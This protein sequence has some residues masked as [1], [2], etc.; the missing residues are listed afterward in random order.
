MNESRRTEF[1]LQRNGIIDPEK[2]R[3]RSYKW[4]QLSGVAITLTLMEPVINGRQQAFSVI[5]QFRRYTE[6]LAIKF[7]I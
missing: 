2:I 4:A 7:A 6:H 3:S 5:I 1:G